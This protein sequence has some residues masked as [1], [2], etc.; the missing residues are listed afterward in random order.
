MKTVLQQR[1]KQ[2][3]S[4]MTEEEKILWYSL[5]AKRFLATKF[6]R[7][8]IIGNY[9]VDFVCFSAKV[10]IELDG[11]QHLEQQEYDKQRTKFLHSQGFS[12]LRFWNYQIHSELDI[13]LDTIFYAIEGGIPPLS[14]INHS[15]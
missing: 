14:L 11:S 3:R 4:N 8:Q 6:K 5:R 2:L 1:A 15:E 7:Q 10:V 13:V 12:V 9:I